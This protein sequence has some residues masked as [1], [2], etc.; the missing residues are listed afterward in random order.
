MAE[1]LR[2]HKSLYTRDALEAAAARFD[3]VGEVTVEDG[4]ADWLVDAAARRP[5][6]QARLALE[7]ANHALVLTIVAARAASG[8][9]TW[10]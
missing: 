4:G 10:R 2:F 3:A 6:H 5:E 7:L 8:G 9:S 1:R